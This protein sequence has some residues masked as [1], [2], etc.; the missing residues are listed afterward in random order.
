[1]L[2]V[3]RWISLSLSMFALCFSVYSC[4]YA[5]HVNRKL[6]RR[7]LDL[8]VEKVKLWK[9]IEEYEA[10]ILRLR[11][12]LGEQGEGLPDEVERVLP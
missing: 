5:H 8:F 7:N 11:S 6:S 9:Q 2:E 10:E 3:M 4:W 12:L 1:M